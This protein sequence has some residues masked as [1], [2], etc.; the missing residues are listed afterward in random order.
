M[1]NELSSRSNKME[2]A[3]E[4]LKSN[5]EKIG[6]NS[7]ISLLLI[8]STYAFI[9]AGSFSEVSRQFPRLAS[10]MII[11]G[12]VVLLLRPFL[13]NK[14]S[15]ILEDSGG[16][17]SSETEEL[18]SKAEVKDKSH[19]DGVI[20]TLFI[21]FYVVS[22]LLVGMLWATPIFV[23]TYLIWSDKSLLLSIPLAVVS[24]L[25][26]YIFYT[27]INLSIDSGLVLYLGYSL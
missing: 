26:A 9:E 3:T 2:A 4:Y 20:T 23:L 21:S 1:D 18:A 11:I 27:S 24:F 10:S 7:F 13:P 16:L 22:S 6:E 5:K 12:C 14:F 8:V 25:L 19:K 15:A 17:M